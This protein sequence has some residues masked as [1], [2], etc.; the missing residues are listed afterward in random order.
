MSEKYPRGKLSADDEGALAMR[1]GVKDKTIII[2]FGE[3]VTWIGL[4]VVTAR[5]M[6]SMLQHHIDTVEGR[7]PS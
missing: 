1:M 3:S 4:D 5:M 2:H 6:V 7:K